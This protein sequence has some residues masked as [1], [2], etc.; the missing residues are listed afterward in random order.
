MIDEK[1]IKIITDNQ[2]F[3]EVFRENCIESRK[4]AGNFTK[5]IDGEKCIK[6]RELFKQFSKEFNFPSYFSYNWSSF[7]ECFNDLEWLGPKKK[8]TL[9][10]KNFDQLLIT[11]QKSYEIF[12]DLLLSGVKEWRTHRDE[13]QFLVEPKIIFT[14]IIQSNRAQLWT[15]DFV[16]LI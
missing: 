2:K 1:Y 12:I 11:D 13:N 9:F 8:I 6:K 5:F 3:D 14:V 10:I 16:E 7:D 4:D 15:K